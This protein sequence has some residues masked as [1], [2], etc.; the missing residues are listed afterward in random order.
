MRA[1]R[2]AAAAVLIT[3]AALAAQQATPTDRARAEAA[4]QRA[5]ERIR[6]L[7]RESEAL[8]AQE[9]T[10]LGDLRKLEVE[11]ELRSEE[12]AKAEHDLATTREALA[13]T[14]TRIETLRH[15]AD[16]E[17]PDVEARLVR[18]YK[19]GNAG[20]WRLLLDIDD[21]RS[22]GRA[23]RTA[24]ALTRIDRERVQEHQRT[25]ESL[26]RERRTL[27]TRVAEIARLSEQATRA[28]AAADRAVK[29]RSVLIDSIDAHRDLN[30]QLTGELEAAQ[31]RLQSTIGQLAAGKAAVVALPL[32]P[33]RGVLPWPLQGI[34]LKRFGTSPAGPTAGTRKDGIE[35]SVGEGQPVR[36]IHEG[37]VAFA[38]QFAGY[39][40]LVILEHGDGAFSLYGD[41]RT[42]DVK[43][44]ERLGAESPVGTSGRN[45]A[46]NPSLY[47]ELRVDGKPVDPLQWLKK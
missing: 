23:Y 27:E 33:F 45:P 31:R 36:A 25:L 5:A 7:E 14:T 28:R 19:L 39:G 2:Y 12:A 29:A 42:I 3:S 38:D 34:V 24:A 30:A 37:T 22:V 11:R 15:A 35:I 32:R 4:S 43:T 26:A 8:A 40:N 18:L 46:G 41:L 44:G 47:F 6:A 17:R 21:V 13:G 16:D 1:S 20:Y 9:K 10:L